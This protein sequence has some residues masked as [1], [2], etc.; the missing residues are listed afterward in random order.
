MTRSRLYV[1]VSGLAVGAGVLAALSAFY[2]DPARAAVGPLPA[3]GLTL[4]ADTRFL[5]GIDV[6]RLTASPFYQRVVK[7]SARP[8]AFKELEEKTG[9]QPERDLDRVLIA[10]RGV[11]PGEPG[12]VL[13]EGRFDRTRLSRALETEKKRGVTW[14]S[15]AGT[16]VYLF[17]EAGK[18]AVALAFMADHTLLMGSA[19]ALE[20]TLE[21]HARGRQPLRENAALVALL[22][23]VKPGST[24][25]MVGDQSLLA[26]LPRTVP[27][28][29]ASPGTGGGVNLPALK[30]LTLTGDLEPQLAFEAVGEAA[31]EPAARNLA[32]LVRGFV[33]LV[34]LQSSQ[35]PE[36]KDLATAISVASEANRVR[37]SARIPHEL[38][39]SLQPKRPEPSVPPPAKP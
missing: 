21:G 16:T 20:A 18:H 2:L 33:A 27:A 19:P 35:K 9:L 3:L 15:H 6:R 39:E 12:L 7:P 4:P 29:G 1:S 34:S 8:D 36:L 11:A 14:K 24:V 25:W 5:V 10:G 37:V 38:I 31:D 22:E 13:V 30:S 28:P 23:G 26:Q 32:D 17:D